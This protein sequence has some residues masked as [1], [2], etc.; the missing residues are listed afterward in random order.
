MAAVAM[1]LLGGFMAVVGIVLSLAALFAAA[2]G[3]AFG[4]SGGLTMLSYGV[5]HLVGGAW[6]AK[7]GKARYSAIAE[8]G[9][10]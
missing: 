10:K 2:G 9:A 5:P 3:D 1:L 4:H 6:L 8:S 7:V